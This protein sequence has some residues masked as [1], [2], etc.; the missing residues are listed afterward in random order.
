M[1][2]YPNLPQ[3]NTTSSSSTDE[4]GHA[5]Y[6]AGPSAEPQQTG[7][8]GENTVQVAQTTGFREANVVSA[9]LGT[10]PLGDT[11]VRS[12]SGIDNTS[13]SDY[14]ERYRLAETGELKSVITYYNV[15]NMFNQMQI[16]NKLYGSYGLSCRMRFK[17]TWNS[18]PTI[19]GLYIMCYIPPGRGIFKIGSATTTRAPPQAL[20]F[21]H[22]ILN[23]ARDTSAELIVP[24]IGETDFIPLLSDSTWKSSVQIGQ[25]A[26]VPFSELKSAESPVKVGF[27]L[28]FALDHVKTM[29]NVGT[30]P[31]VQSGALLAQ[32]VE[33]IKQSKIVSN[34][35][36]YIA[37]WVNSKTTAE[38]GWLQRT[39]GWLT[40]GIA[41][42]AKLFG[43]SKPLTMNALQPISSAS[44][45]DCT[46][47]EG[48]YVGVSFANNYDAEITPKDL[49]GDGEDPMLF[50][51]FLRD[52]LL[53]LDGT[54]G[55]GMLTFSV[56]QT[57][58]TSL[59]SIQYAPS[60]WYWHSD[61]GWFGNRFYTLSRIFTG[62]RGS[63]VLNFHTA[64][65]KFHS[66]RIRVVY[67]PYN[68]LVPELYDNMSYTYT[69]V[70]DISDPA[71]WSIRLP[72]VSLT[73]FVLNPS[74]AGVLVF[75]VENELVASSTVSTSI[76]IPITVTAGDDFEFVGPCELASGSTSK[77]MQ[78]LAPDK[79]VY[80]N[81]PRNDGFEDYNIDVPVVEG[82]IEFLP[83]TGSS[84]EAHQESFGDPVR[85]LN[86]VIKRSWTAFSGPLPEN[87]NGVICRF[88]PIGKGHPNSN[89]NYA[90]TDPM[91]VIA[92]MFTLARGSMRFQAQNYLPARVYHT[93]SNVSG[94]VGRNGIVPT[95][96]TLG[97]QMAPFGVTEATKVQVPFYSETPSVNYWKTNPN[98]PRN[99]TIISY[100]MAGA[101]ETIVISRSAGDDFQFGLPSG[102]PIFQEEY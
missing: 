52:Q 76:Q 55:T 33:G 99:S 9:A 48:N 47:A 43:W 13:V 60:Q 79:Y 83:N 30:L 7:L 36:G 53:P 93:L 49:T 26:I 12:T 66:G 71:T 40:G 86:T 28:F 37:D 58:G 27:S 84:V 3:T 15:R 20:T 87:T 5:I 14:L 82:D 39:A 50:T 90:P 4:I 32:T 97:G 59:G 100:D 45:I 94:Q 21:P 77:L 11:N 42:V 31:V 35:L 63:L 44:F 73:P 68:K 54:Y 56:G 2:T 41:K 17:L 67:S 22:V 70:L 29:G 72:Y 88:A 46:T 62:F 81:V 65:T 23:I 91:S 51:N 69:W 101:P 98:Y 24:Y 8:F 18:D 61:Y 57:P 78:V 74:S 25:L 16:Q 92:S 38:S 85:S 19:S 34:G 80:D 1:E 102:I 6:S 96:W 64:C 89:L 95:K 10:R 75:Y